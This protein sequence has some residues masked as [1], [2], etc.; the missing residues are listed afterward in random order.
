MI[1]KR[2]DLEE[3]N[4][5]CPSE[6]V[7][8][9]L[10]RGFPEDL[11]MEIEVA[12]F[13]VKVFGTV[14]SRSFLSIIAPDAS[15]F[16][17]TRTRRIDLCIWLEERPEKVICDFLA[18]AKCSEAFSGVKVGILDIADQYIDVFELRHLCTIIAQSF[19]I[20]FDLG[21][22]IVEKGP[23][24]LREISQVCMFDSFKSA[25]CRRFGLSKADTWNISEDNTQSIS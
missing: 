4:P 16:V 6:L 1:L 15:C 22:E 18:A 2:K 7:N 19:P 21:E 5:F 13:E 3:I 20:Q 24:N 17:S 11:S 10:D 25:S 14:V 23:F 8:C 12:T 9:K